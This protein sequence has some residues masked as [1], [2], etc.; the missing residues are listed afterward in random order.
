MIPAAAALA[1]LLT[2]GHR[3]PLASRALVATGVVAL[4]QPGLGVVV[5]VGVGVVA[6]VARLRRTGGRPEDGDVVLLADLVV[7]GLR[8]GLTLENALRSAAEDVP[9]PLGDE[10]RMVL[11]SV[12]RLGLGAAL[13]RATG[14]GERLYRLAAQAAE[15]G[16]ALAPSI[17]GLAGEL[18][19]DQHTR[20]LAAA[21]RLPVR[22]LLPLALLILPG[23]VLVVVGPALIGS[24]ARLEIGL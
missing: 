10:V 17:E 5:A 14:R 2:Y 6:V 13:A 12:R 19:H 11:R 3:L 9:A 15:S 7:L 24:L 22:L 18:R 21:R 16:A 4:V 23:F 20:A 1:G 8:A